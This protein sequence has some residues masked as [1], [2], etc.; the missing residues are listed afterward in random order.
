MSLTKIETLLIVPVFHHDGP[1]DAANPHRNRKRDN[2][3]P[4]RA[5][6]ATSANMMLGGSG[7]LNKGIDLERFHGVG[8][9][10]FQDYGKAGNELPRR[11]DG[12]GRVVTATHFDPVARVEPIH[13][14]ETMGLGT[15]TFLEGAPASKKAVMQRRESETQMPE[16]GFAAPGGTLGRKKSLAQRF[17]GGIRGDRP[18]RSPELPRY[19]NGINDAAMPDSPPKPTRAPPI[20]SREVQSAGGPSRIHQGESNPFDSMYDEAYDRKGA[21]ISIA[22]RERGGRARAPSSPMRPLERRIT[23]DSADGDPENRPTG[24]LS[25]VKSLKGGRR[26]RRPS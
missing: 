1:F 11:P 6:P 4:M 8:E 15:S 23:T 25:R 16:Q 24:F 10:G 14:E 17:R 9:E 20:P 7:P 13:A 21:S 26:V 5:F 18:T 19:N 3:A 2:R 22:E 12:P